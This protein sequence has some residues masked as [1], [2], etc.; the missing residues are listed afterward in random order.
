MSRR[1]DRRR[2]RGGGLLLLLGAMAL[3]VLSG[4]LASNLP[5]ASFSLTPANHGYPPLDV[6]FD[7]SASSS[8]NG[9]IVSYAWDFDDGETASGKIVSRTFTEKG[10]YG[11]SL[12]VTDSSGEIGARTQFVEALNRVPIAAFTPSAYT[13][14]VDQPIRFDASDSYDPDGA[15][16]DR[17]IWD[18]DTSYDSDDDGDPANDKDGEG[19]VTIYKFNS[20][21]TYNISLTVEDGDGV[22]SEP[23]FMDL[24]VED[25]DDD[26]ALPSSIIVVSIAAAALVMAFRRKR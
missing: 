4:C 10:T 18:F 15:G 20:T 17:Y 16:I 8:P 3:V 12:V 2:L 6:T 24:K 21:G 25:E 19:R 9:A 26:G 7:A 11:V 23:V 5:Q 14:G 1:S 22:R 13:V